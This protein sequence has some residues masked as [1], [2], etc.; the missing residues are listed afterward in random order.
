L[1]LDRLH[2]LRRVLR[3]L[4]VFLRGSMRHASLL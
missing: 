1:L 3:L 2:L 4:L